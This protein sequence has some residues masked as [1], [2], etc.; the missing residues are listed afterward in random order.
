MI[1]SF[2]NYNKLKIIKNIKKIKIEK[3]KKVDVLY[4]FVIL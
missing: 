2:K 1:L 4:D 3:I